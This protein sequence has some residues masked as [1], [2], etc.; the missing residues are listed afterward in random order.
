MAT[1]KNRIEWLDAMRGFTMV[2][3]VAYH[4]GLI[5]FAESARQSASMSLLVLFRMPLFFFVSGY[6]A[7][8]PKFVWTAVSTARQLWKKFHVQLLPTILFMCAYAVIRC[9][10]FLPAMERML[11]SPTKGGYW[12][13]LALLYMFILYY[14][15]AFIE[16]HFRWRE[17]SWHWVPITLFWVASVILYETAYM[18]K[19]FSY[20]KDPFWKVSSLIQVVYFLQFFL[21]GNIVRRYWKTAEKIFDSK[22]FVPMVVI[23]AF[24]CASDYLRWHNL[25]LVWANLPR[26]LAM[27]MTMLL[28]MLF[29]RRYQ[30]SFTKET[31]LGR[32]LQYIGTRTLDIY[33]L[34]YIF[35]PRIPAVGEWL[36]TNKPDFVTGTTLCVALALVVIAFCL[37]TSSLL[38][39]SPL[40]QE[41]LFGVK[42]PSE[43]T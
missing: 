25:R 4:V 43:N 14:V 27:Y 32:V 5:T 21:M 33:L 19:V 20:P 10:E 2:M 34:H 13:T 3:V 29:F 40:F 31:R 12:F 41:H 36:N 39:I 17:R 11:Q 6:L 8:R 38:R 30:D 37:I 15:F 7:F 42:A 1:T 35:L 9:K 16:Q 26:T 24:F 22:W 23:V 28:C 18:P